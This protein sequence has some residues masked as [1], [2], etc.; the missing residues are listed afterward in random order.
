[1]PYPAFVVALVTLGVAQPAAGEV[2]IG[3]ADTD[4]TAVNTALVNQAG[5]GT[6]G[7]V[8]VSGEGLYWLAGDAI[9]R[10]DLDGSD[11]D[12]GFITGLHSASGLTAG[13]GYLYWG[14]ESIGRARLDGTGVEPSFMTPSGGA[15]DVAANAQHLYWTS[16]VGIGRANLDGTEA[17]PAL[18]ETGAEDESTELAVNGARLFWVYVTGDPLTRFYAMGRARLDGGGAEYPIM[19]GA[20]YGHPDIYGS[21]GA[22]DRR[23]FFIF[24]SWSPDFFR[25]EINSFDANFISGSAT[26]CCSPSWPSIS[27]PFVTDSLSGGV[28]VDR[29]RVYWAHDA[30]R[31]LNCVLNPRRTNQ[32]QR[33][34]RIRFEVWLWDCERISVH[35]SGRVKIAGERYGLKP[36]AAF[37]GPSF[38]DWTMEPVRAVA[39]RPKRAR[40]QEILAALKDGEAAYAR[41]R[42][43]IADPSGNSRVSTYRVRLDR[44]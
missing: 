35:A 15:N 18:L 10:A 39:L 28:A 37:T 40:R 7:D 29:D 44:R 34:R 9:A 26:G 8:A 22:D 6:P 19:R 32:R 31:W 33:G 17:N 43:E 16:A 2:S 23:V 14:G 25:V 11:V 30:D 24:N 36:K 27:D 12:L 21:I 3:S 42:L 38:N 5:S 4:G 20:P 1:M 41:I 13:G